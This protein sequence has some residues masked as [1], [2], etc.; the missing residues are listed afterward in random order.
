MKIIAITACIAGIAHTYIA[1]EK[2]ERAAQELG[3]DIKVETQ[4]TIGVENQLNDQDVS[5][6]DVVIIAHDIKVYNTERFEHKRV[7]DIP[8][9][10]VMKNP[11]SLLLS[12]EKKI[13]EES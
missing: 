13:L 4:G 2:L 12:I 10:I 7:V 5:N 9:S 3:H 1:K 6:A 8:I 11:K